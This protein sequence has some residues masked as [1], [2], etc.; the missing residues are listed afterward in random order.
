MN[1]IAG[2]IV[3][4][5]IVAIGF[6][7]LQPGEQEMFSI[8]PTGLITYDVLVPP[9]EIIRVDDR[10]AKVVFASR[11]TQVAG[12]FGIPEGE[13]PFPTF[14]I[15]PG[16]GVGKEAEHANLGKDLRARG[17]A[18][19]TLDQRGVGETGGGIDYQSDVIAYQNNVETE[20]HK[21]IADII[22]A[23]NLAGSFPEVG[24]VYV[25]GISLGGRNA[26]I[27][28]TLEPGI[29]GVVGIATGGYDTQ[30]LEPDVAEFFRSIDPEEYVAGVAPRRFVMIHSEA[31]PV[32]PFALA[33]ELFIAAEEPK[34]LVVSQEDIHGWT[35]ADQELLSFLDF[36]R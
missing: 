35:S 36:W 28:A 31:D 16:A 27:A 9:S 5:V 22:A 20:S 17:F 15:V 21:Q 33:E 12:L 14:I 10:T 4:A 32:I 1:I 29:S 7:V 11:G 26:I 8:T 25:A 19:F 30:G 6:F 34:L 3:V 18:T 23:A 24:N 13:P 2:V